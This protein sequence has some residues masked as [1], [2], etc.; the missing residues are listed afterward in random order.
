M[1]AT[2]NTD[3]AAIRARFP[4]LANK[5]YL[6]SCAYGALSTDVTASFQAYLND[7]LEKG[8]DWE[9][10]VERNESVRTAVAQFLGATTN[11]IAVTASASAGI[12]SV[13]SS[14]RW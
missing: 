10:W 1:T 5:T 3:W 2:E 11:E 6:N 7:R 9:F 4:I 13:A 14:L 8:T 12:N